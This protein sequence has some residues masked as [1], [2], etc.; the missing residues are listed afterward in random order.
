MEKERK[1]NNSTKKRKTKLR[2]KVIYT[3]FRP[4]FALYFKLRYNY[5][6]EK[7]KGSEDGL[8][9]LSNHATT[10]DPFFVA[11]SF[12]KPL[13]FVASDQLFNLGFASRVIEFLV[14][15]IPKTK[16]MSDIKSVRDIKA[17]LDEGA[18]V[19]LFPEG[20]RTFIGRTVTIP[21][22]IGKLVK[23]F[24]K[25]IVL[26]NLK[27]SYLS[28]PRWALKPRKGVMKGEIA[29]VL[30]YSDYKD[31][32]PKEIYEEIKDY[33]F[34][35][36]FSDQEK[37]N[38]KYR[39]KKKAEYIENVLYLC[40]KCKK[41]H[42]M[43]S[44]GERFWCENCGLEAEYT[45]LGKIISD[46]AEMPFDNVYKWHTWQN[47]YI[48]ENG[49]YEN[50]LETPFKPFEMTLYKDERAKKR[51]KI[52][53]GTFKLYSDRLEMI[54]K[55]GEDLTLPLEEIVG[56]TPQT[57]GKMQVYSKKGDFVITMA[58]NVSAL[59]YVTLFYMNKNK[60]EGKTNEFLGQ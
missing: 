37:F 12:K 35:D 59:S 31:M 16:G 15:P 9:V 40:P 21:E 10:M 11:L 26:Y 19:A 47:E 17:Y 20:N 36:A 51:I 28:K 60:A 22:Q 46:D 24:K 27:G 32:T 53:D 52:F 49:L 30:T 34:V 58:K 54:G 18:N 29:K 48:E 25:T 7:Y 4:V 33:L 42:T 50:M 56:M 3:L 55:N 6:Y 2:H 57:M 41:L 45:E 43:K 8:L 14:A 38:V 5:S 23:L 1:D 39:G 13:F 44:K